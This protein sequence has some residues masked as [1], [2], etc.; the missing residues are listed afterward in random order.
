MCNAL[1]LPYSNPEM[2]ARNVSGEPERGSPGW[3]L[4]FVQNIGDGM[5]E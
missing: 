1:G 5:P 4:V 3:W 2:L